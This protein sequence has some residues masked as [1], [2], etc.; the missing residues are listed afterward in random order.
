MKNPSVAETENTARY[1]RPQ[2]ILL[3]TNLLLRILILEFGAGQQMNLFSVASAARAQLVMAPCQEDEFWRNALTV[4]EE[5][6]GKWEGTTKTIRAA[7]EQLC[8]ALSVMEKLSSLSDGQR[9]AISDIRRH[10]TVAE[11]LPAPVFTW[12]QF[13]AF[14]ETAFTHYRSHS[15][16]NL[17][18]VIAIES[19]AE[20]RMRLRNPPCN[21]RKQWHWGDC[22]IWETIRAL[23]SRKE[24]VVWFATTDTDF[25]YPKQD[26]VLHPFLQREVASL[27]GSLAFFH[28]NRNIGLE[29]RT[30]YKLLQ[31]LIAYVPEVVAKTVREFLASAS[32]LSPEVS[33]Q[34]VAA[35]L[36][37]LPYRERE[38]L[39]LRLGLGDGYWYT[40]EEVGQIF[41]VSQPRIS[42]I[43]RHALPQFYDAL[44]QAAQTPKGDDPP[45]NEP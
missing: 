26:A 7:F 4:W 12:E 22:V 34:D 42:Q 30:E 13:A 36:A 14:A 15:P 10:K 38:I 44:R 5:H 40:Q 18:D 29:V 11:R 28:E 41:G 24:G 1:P 21:D 25:S 45:S 27:G 19:A 39:K 31:Q 43:E 35:A 23:I 32:G 6:R 8:D 9:A 16:P 17:L 3:D 37:D 20:R 33:R 2:F